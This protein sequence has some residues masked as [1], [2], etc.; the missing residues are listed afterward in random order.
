MTSISGLSSSL[1]NSYEKF[2]SYKNELTTENMFQMLSVEVG[3]DGETITKDQ[4]DSYIESAK[5]GDIKISNQEIKALTTIQDNW[6]TIAG[7]KD[8]ESISFTNMKDQ[9]QLLLS[10]VTGGSSLSSSSDSGSS[11]A[12]DSVDDYIVSQ[13]LGTSN[14]KSNATSLLKTLLT[15]N[16]DEADDANAGLIATLT[17]II[18]DYESASSVEMEA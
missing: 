7:S 2:Q 9:S 4:L 16:T 13:T 15:G 12:S 18:A 6:N 5:N 3:G 11:S 14:D 17:N 1:L 10:A 8:A